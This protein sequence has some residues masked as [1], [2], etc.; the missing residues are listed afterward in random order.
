V[1][2]AF[3]EH[4]VEAVYGSA[5]KAV[6]CQQLGEKPNGQR[7]CRSSAHLCRFSRADILKVS[8]SE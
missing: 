3:F 5:A 8:K 7:G 2:S 6:D 1:R 4:Q